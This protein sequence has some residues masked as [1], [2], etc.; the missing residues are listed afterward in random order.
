MVEVGSGGDKPEM[1]KDP[2]QLASYL[3]ISMISHFSEKM[4]NMITDRLTLEKKR[5]AATMVEFGKDRG[6]MDLGLCVESDTSVKQI[7]YTSR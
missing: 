4:E 1:G 7:L 5:L 6:T 2:L 3:I